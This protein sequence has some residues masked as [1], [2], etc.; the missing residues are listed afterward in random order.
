M[1]VVKMPGSFSG[2]E[3]YQT[4]NLEE[5]VRVRP[6]IDLKDTI[7]QLKEVYDEYV[8]YIRGL[9]DEEWLDLT[10]DAEKH[11]SDEED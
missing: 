9:T 10:K 7:M 1:R 8:Q 3:A 4:L 11:S 2:M 5:L 6:H